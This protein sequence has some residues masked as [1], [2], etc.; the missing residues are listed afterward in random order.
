MSLVSAADP[1]LASNGASGAI[2]WSWLSCIG[3]QMAG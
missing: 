3:A 1:M 2:S